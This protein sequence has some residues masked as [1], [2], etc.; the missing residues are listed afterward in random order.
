MEL[1]EEVYAESK[2]SCS[3]EWGIGFHYDPSYSQR[4]VL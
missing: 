1:D 4:A 3:P 2:G